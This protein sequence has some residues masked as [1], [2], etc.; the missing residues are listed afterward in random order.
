MT[1]KLNLLPRWHF[2]MLNDLRRN[3]EFYKAI[4][5][6]NKRKDSKVLDIGSGSGL[7]SL[8]LSKNIYCKSIYSVEESTILVDMSKIVF[9]KNNAKSV[10]V[11][12]KN[13]KELSS[14][15]ISGHA[16]LLVCEIFDCGLLGEGALGT[17][18]HAWEHLLNKNSTIIPAY[19]DVYVTGIESNEL[20]RKHRFQAKS[21]KLKLNV[22][23][24]CDSEEPYDAENLKD[25]PFKKITETKLILSVNFSNIEQLKDIIKEST[26]TTKLECIE[27]GHIDALVI[28]FKLALNEEISITTDPHSDSVNCWEQGIKYADHQYQLTKGDYVGVSVHISSDCLRLNILEQIPEKHECMKCSND[29]IS[30]MN[31]ENLVKYL[32]SIATSFSKNLKVLDLYP[33]PLVGLILMQ[34]GSECYC[35]LKNDADINLLYHICALNNIDVKNLKVLSENDVEIL[36]LEKEYFDVIVLDAVSVNGIINEKMISSYE[37]WKCHLKPNGVFIPSAVNLYAQLIESEYLNMC[38]KVDDKNTCGFQI[39]EFVNEYKV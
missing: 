27:S 26:F 5:S 1:V 20:A 32:E 39:A 6:Y 23:L 14:R 36:E 24:T 28:W 15:D 30:F 34:S 17:I 16:D 12:N 4:M 35:S 37:Q 33:L 19:A 2:R 8:Y 29:V 38:S 7:L 3:V 10:N 13:S 9:E 31:D 11:I 21:F 22:C 25:I 18:I